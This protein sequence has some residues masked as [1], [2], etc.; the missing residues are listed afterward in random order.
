VDSQGC[1]QDILGWNGMTEINDP[2]RAIGR[3]QYAFKLTDKGVF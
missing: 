3:E 1:R 2:G